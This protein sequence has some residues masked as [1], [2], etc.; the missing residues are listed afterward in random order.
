MS[1]MRN[2]IKILTIVLY[3][4]KKERKQNAPVYVIAQEHSPRYTLHI[5][6]MEREVMSDVHRMSNF[7]SCKQRSEDTF[8]YWNK[9]GN[10]FY[11]NRFFM[12]Y[13]NL[14]AGSELQIRMTGE[15]FMDIYVKDLHC[16]CCG[17]Q[18]NPSEE[19]VTKVTMCQTC[20]EVA[21]I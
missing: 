21:D 1:R 13:A 11:N 8:Q 18:L 15:H 10:I 2:K 20:S 17:K 19:N 7:G 12:N 3:K 5:L 9:L 6:C 4:N 14:K 16:K